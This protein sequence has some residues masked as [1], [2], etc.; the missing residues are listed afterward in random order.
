MNLSF[1]ERSQEKMQHHYA[2]FNDSGQT[3]DYPYPPKAD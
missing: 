3:T 2:L 1:P